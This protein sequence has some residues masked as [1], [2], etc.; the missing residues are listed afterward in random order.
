MNGVKRG[1]INGLIVL[2]VLAVGLF[3]LRRGGSTRGAAAETALEPLTIREM[4]V[5]CA[6]AG[7]LSCAG[8]TA[9][10][11]TGEDDDFEKIDEAL[12][13][14]GVEELDFLLLSHFDKDHIGA[15]AEL[16]GRYRV[17]TVFLP[18]YEGSGKRY[19]ALINALDSCDDVRRISEYCVFDWHGVMVELIPAEG[20]L[21]I[22]AGEEIDNDMSLLCRLTLGDYKFLFAGDIQTPRIEALLASGLDMQ[23]SWLKYPAHGR[24]EDAQRALIEKC[25][26][27]YAVV[28]CSRKNPMDNA[29]RRLLEDSNIGIFE[30]TSFDV[31]TV[32]NGKSIKISG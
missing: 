29:T 23:C 12:Q 17:K 9:M 14:E 22:P 26:P 15:A 3:V 32:C 21:D 19:D 7:I 6:D 1:I 31:L 4:K 13:K 18:D 27:I 2:A 10:I 28:C 8:Y 11:D 5:G 16:L 20:E 25:A 24:Y 30:T